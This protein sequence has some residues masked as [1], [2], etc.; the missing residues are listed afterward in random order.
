MYQAVKYTNMGIMNLN[1]FL[2]DNCKRTTIHKYALSS[3]KNKTIVIDTSIYLYKY[4]GQNA[5]FENFYTMIS[6]FR[7]NNINPLFIFDGKAPVEKYDLL[8][9]RRNEKLSAEQEYNTL[10]MKIES[11]DE[12][13]SHEQQK[14]EL[15]ELKLLKSRFLRVRYSDIIMVKKLMTAYG[16]M[17]HEAE[18]EADQVCAAMV[19]SGKAWACMSDDMDMFVYG[20]PRVIRHFSITNQNVLLYKLENILSDLKIDM[21]TFRQITVL[22]GTDYNITSN[23]SFVETMKWYEEYIHC[24]ENMNLDFYDWLYKNTKYI[25]NYESLLKIYHLFQLDDLNI[26]RLTPFNVTYHNY[27]K[28]ELH[29]MMK[30]DGFVF[31]KSTTNP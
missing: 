4:I 24:K 25:Q 26:H 6:Q 13:V 7:E 3:L 15:L 23:T 30:D 12:H 11:Y 27:D 31:A 21:T 17:Y 10:R 16:V 29:R 9:A 2:I 28:D 1:R 19:L 5:L 18:G 20:C 8:D 22:S 14:K